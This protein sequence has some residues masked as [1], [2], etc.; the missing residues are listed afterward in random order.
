MYFFPLASKT[1]PFPLLCTLYNSL[2]TLSGELV[3]WALCAACEKRLPKITSRGI[4]EKLIVL[5]VSV[6]QKFAI[7]RKH[8]TLGFSCG[9]RSECKLKGK[10]YLRGMLSRRQP[11]ALMLAYGSSELPANDSKSLPK[12]IGISLL[13]LQS[14]IQTTLQILHARRSLHPELSDNLS[15]WGESFGPPDSTHPNYPQN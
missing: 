13:V 12:A 10:D 4:N 8:I 5:I 7:L 11:Q 14:Q 6:P 3:G 2:M 9:A 15:I 1:P